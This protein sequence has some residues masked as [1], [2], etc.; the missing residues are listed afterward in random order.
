MN[1]ELCDFCAQTE[2]SE[3]LHNVSF[4]LAPGT[5]TLLTGANGA[6]KSTILRGIMGLGGLQYSGKVLFGGKNN[7]KLD[8]DERARRGIFMSFQEPVAIEGLSLIEAL[9]SA[10]E[11]KG[12]KLALSAVKIRISDA[13]EKVGL[14]P[15][16]ASRELNHK[17][18]GGEKKKCEIAQM[19]VLQ[20]KLVLLDEIDSGLD[21]KSCK[22]ISKILRDYQAETGATYLIVSHN[23]KILSELTVDQELIV[24]DGRIVKK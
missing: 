22:N 23:L 24:E 1:L 2:K 21:A 8:I 10:L 16:I 17:L 20:P 19:L 4:T 13:L 12:E 3:I 6:G 15:F 14:S 5:T 11:A 9:R 7:S 18:S